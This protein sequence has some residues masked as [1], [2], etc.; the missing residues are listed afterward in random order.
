MQFSH[1]GN[2]WR[3][4]CNMDGPLNSPSIQLCLYL[5]LQIPVGLGATNKSP[6]LEYTDIDIL[7][8]Q[9]LQETKRERDMNLRKRSENDNID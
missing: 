6:E 1:V 2:Q 7:K 5:A 8:T 3:C 4:T 9:A